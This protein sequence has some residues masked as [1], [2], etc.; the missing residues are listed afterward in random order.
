[1]HEGEV[2]AERNLLSL[3][4]PG[5]TISCIFLLG[6][7]LFYFFCTLDVN[8]SISWIR[9]FEICIMFDYCSLTGGIKIQG[10]DFI[11]NLFMKAI[12][13]YVMLSNQQACVESISLI[14]HAMY[15]IPHVLL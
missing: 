9:F 11:K 5:S 3:L 4:R 12:L 6:S 14:L 15:S 13:G 7:I 1:M 10:V 2:Q 8:H